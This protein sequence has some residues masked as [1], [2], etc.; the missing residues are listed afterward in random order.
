MLSILHFLLEFLVHTLIA[1]TASMDVDT[2]LGLEETGADC[3]L[4]G[5]SHGGCYSGN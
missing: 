5:M 2:F 3:M 4:G 1:L